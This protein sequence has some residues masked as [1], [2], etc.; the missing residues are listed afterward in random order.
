V[1]IH[2][3]GQHAGQRAVDS[4]LRRINWLCAGRRWRKTTFCASRAV[5][6]AVQG[7]EIVWGA[8]T[9]RQVRIGWNEI[10]KATV[11]VATFNE[12][13]M[14]A[15]FP[16][17]GNG[18]QGIIH[19]VSM[20]EPDNARGYTADGIVLDEASESP[21]VG[22]NQVLRPMLMDT[23]GWLLA[24][25]TPKGMNYTWRNTMDAIHGD[26]P[27]AMAWQIP[28]LGCV[29]AEDKLLRVPHPLENPN[30]R[31]AELEAM[32]VSMPR[33]DFQQ[34]ILAEF[35]DD[36]GGV[37]HGVNDCIDP[38]LSLL[39]GPP[40]RVFQY[41]IGLD[42]AKYLDYTVAVVV[43]LQSKQIVD[44]VRYNRVDWVEQVERIK[45]LAQ[46]WNNALV[47]MD[48]TG[49]GDPIYDQLSYAKVRVHGYKFTPQTKTALINNAV[50]LV[51]QKAVRY[52]HIPVLLD[53]L[54]ALQ[55]T[56]TESGLLQ[57]GAPE[58]MHD[59]AAMAFCLALWLVGHTGGSGVLTIAG[60]NALSGGRISDF[61]G[62]RL[63]EMEF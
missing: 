33:R 46:T 9:F 38:S 27:E 35:L 30:L 5:Q 13:R 53:E 43:D 26:N 1:R 24:A 45:R 39:S 60:V 8:P 62:M 28:S 41:V 3:P 25:F 18:R 63:K 17:L 47:W 50:L 10:R 34:E 7:D 12:S 54:K 19:F 51:E 22:W 44:F 36:V 40:N 20:D 6:R 55:Y 59:D 4:Q 11:D 42:L 21:E 37:F 16:A 14:E 56:R 32:F 57:I 48:S 61:G 31:F 23:N 2:L 29:I 52:P 58:G 49:L 15:V